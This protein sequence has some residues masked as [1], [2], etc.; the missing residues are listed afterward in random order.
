MASTD[1]VYV[2]AFYFL[3]RQIRVI[4]LPVTMHC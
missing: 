3:Y 2:R 1:L 4:I